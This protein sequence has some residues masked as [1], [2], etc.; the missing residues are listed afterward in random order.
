MGSEDRNSPL[1]VL[2]LALFV[3]FHQLGDRDMWGRL[4]T[5]AAVCA[6]NMLATG[7]YAVPVL[8]EK[9]FVD[10]RPPGAFWL[11]AGSFALTGSQDE[12]AARLPSA[13]AAL[14][15]V[16]LVFAMGRKAGGPKAGLLSALVLLGMVS[17]VWLGRTSQQ[18]MPLTLAVTAAWWAMWGS[19]DARSR[20]RSLHYALAFMF[21]MGLGVLVKGPAIV[22]SLVPVVLYVAYARRWRDVKW[23]ALLLTLPVG[24]ALAGSWYA[25]IWFQ[26]PEFRDVLIERF[27]NQNNIHVEPFYD[28]LVRLPG[29][30]G[31]A[32][33][34]LPVLVLGWRKTSAENRRGPLGLFLIGFAAQLVIFSLFPSK[35]TH[36]L[37]PSLPL[38]ALAIGTVMAAHR[39]EERP[40]FARMGVVLGV[41]TLLLAIG[42]LFLAP[43]LGIL[44]ADAGRTHPAPRTILTLVVG[45][46]LALGYLVMHRKELRARSWR[47]GWT[48]WVIG[49][50]FLMGDVVPRLDSRMSLA[51]F[52]SEVGRIVPADARLASLSGHAG[53]EYYAGRSMRS[54]GRRKLDEYLGNPD[55]YLIA[56]DDAADSVPEERRRVV[57]VH[58]AE[59][60]REPA[61]LLRG[62]LTRSLASRGRQPP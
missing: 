58:D 60:R 12:W 21:A 33:F 22:L 4:E 51:P 28:Y 13:A 52:A 46:W 27:T 25:H 15:C 8:M 50:A 49:L 57:Y 23:G 55:H 35:R 29:L 11:V 41:L 34:L 44:P 48:C 59:H 20:S 37:L 43:R 6:R 40:L 30:L 7:D 18:D 10:N 39:A 16:L 1:V 17:F 19:L 42:G 24:L 45:V 9:P 56:L 61:Y 31:P 54:I 53:L 38:L 3:F 5:E 47:F 2:V 26:H 32:L 36:Y 14:L 62:V